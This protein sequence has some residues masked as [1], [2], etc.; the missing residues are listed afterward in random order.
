VAERREGRVVKLTVF[1]DESQRMFEATKE[2]LHVGRILIS[3]EMK[4]SKVNEL[5]AVFL[6]LELRFDTIS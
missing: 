2:G 1:D 6:L 5:N 3:Y 4:R